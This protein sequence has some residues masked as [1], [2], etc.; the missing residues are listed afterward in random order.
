VLATIISRS[1]VVAEARSWLG[2]RFRHRGHTKG[3]GADCIGVV[4]GSAINLGLLPDGFV[5]PAYAPLPSNGLMMGNCEKYLVRRAQPAPGA[6]ALLRFD[7]E[8]THLAIFGDHKLYGVSL[9]HSYARV[10]K[11]VEHGLD[12]LW[13]GR[14]IA[15]YDF[16]G[17]T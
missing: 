16:P 14:L 5:M 2:T 3:V 8:P 15:V 17:V 7:Y 9:I 11:V 1:D 4:Y 12:S 6:I 13:R 10:R